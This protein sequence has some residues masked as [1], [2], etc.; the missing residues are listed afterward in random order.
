MQ[1]LFGRRRDDQAADAQQHDILRAL[2]TAKRW[3]K[4]PQ[5]SVDISL[6]ISPQ[7]STAKLVD[8]LPLTCLHPVL[9]DFA[10][11]PA[12]LVHPALGALQL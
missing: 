9:A 7:R 2:D 8:R 3:R 6:V 10:Q 4:V 12:M 1:E 5:R 11:D